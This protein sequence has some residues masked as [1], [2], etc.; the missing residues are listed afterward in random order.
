MRKMIFVFGLMAAGPVF[1]G[2]QTC[3]FTTRVDQVERTQTVTLA[4]NDLMFS[5]TEILL[6]A[7]P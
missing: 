5:G 7:R 1:A 6:E 3:E 2:S 4:Q